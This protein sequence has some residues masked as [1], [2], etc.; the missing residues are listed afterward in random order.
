MRGYIIWLLVFRAPRIDGENLDDGIWCWRKICNNRLRIWGHLS[1]PPHNGSVCNHHPLS[2][3]FQDAGSRMLMA[4]FQLLLNRRWLVLYPIW[5]CTNIPERGF[6][7]ESSWSSCWKWCFLFPYSKHPVDNNVLL[8]LNWIEL[9]Y[10][11]VLIVKSCE[12]EV[13]IKIGFSQL[14]K[15]IF[16]VGFQGY[17][18][19]EVWFLCK[20]LVR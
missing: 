11:D 5:T 16:G 3:K 17:E 18:W 14:L 15:F 6:L 2:I 12:K 13:A 4:F 8:P 20:S 7:F 19:I 10:M 1:V 9:K